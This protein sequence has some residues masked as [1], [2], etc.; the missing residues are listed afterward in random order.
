M[1]KI[2]KYYFLRFLIF[3]N[4]L[5]K[6]KISFKKLTNLLK[7]QASYYLKS[8]SAGNSPVMMNFELWNEC[9]ESCVFCRSNVGEIY[10]VNP[11]SKEK[12]NKGKLDI[13]V[14][15]K[16]IDELKEY[17]VLSIPYINGEPFL[18]KNLYRAVDYASKN[19]VGTLIASN[20]I[21]INDRNAKKILDSGLDFLKV[22]ISGFSQNVH[23][24]EHRKGNVEIIKKNLENISKLNLNGKYNCLIMLDYIHYKHNNHE[25]EIAKKFAEENNLIFNLRKVLL[26]E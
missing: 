20:G 18:S 8:T 25:I 7:T 5:R 9:N 22:H 15:E 17:L 23:S 4:L 26:M 3:L 1:F 6:R 2:N 11:L 24:I 16:I 21:I 10:N 19:N 14:Y 13:E 12:I